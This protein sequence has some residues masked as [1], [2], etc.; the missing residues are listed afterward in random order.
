MPV[1]AVPKGPKTHGFT[2]CTLAPP[3]LQGAQLSVE[4]LVP[5]AAAIKDGLCWGYF[6]DVTAEKLAASMQTCASALGSTAFAVS[7]QLVKGQC[8]V[9]VGAGRIGERAFVRTDETYATQV[10]VGGG[11]TTMGVGSKLNAFEVTGDKFTPLFSGQPCDALDDPKVEVIGSIS[12][13][14][15]DE[16]KT[17][18][19]ELRQW[20]CQ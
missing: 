4:Q 11:E 6:S 15:R 19:K 5:L 8:T 13:Q 12:K 9:E 1:A 16:W 20:F 7:L 2:S 17:Y 10:M 3:H 14:A 18:P